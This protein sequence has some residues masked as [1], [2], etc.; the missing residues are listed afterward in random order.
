MA[1]WESRRTD[2]ADSCPTLCSPAASRTRRCWLI[3][4]TSRSRSSTGSAPRSTLNGSHGRSRRLHRRAEAA[5]EIGPPEGEV[6]R[7]LR[8][9]GGVRLRRAA[10]DVHPPP[11]QLDEEQHVQRL[12]PHRLHGEEVTGDDARGLL[13]QECRPAHPAPAGTRPQPMAAQQRSDCRGGYPDPKLRQL[14][15]NAEVAHRG[16]SRATRRTSVRVAPAR[17]G[18]PGRPRARQDHFCRTSSRCQ[19]SN[20]GGVTSKPRHA[21]RDRRWLATARKSRSLQR[22]RGRPPCRRST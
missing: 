18:R 21:S 22:N 5:F 4:A 20:V 6:S 12:Q 7:L 10:A 17:G 11:A 19:R 1:A 14:P 8:N 13:A 9:P 2:V 15:L 3:R 16:F